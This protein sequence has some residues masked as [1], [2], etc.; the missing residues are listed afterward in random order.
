AA[1]YIPKNEINERITGV[2]ISYKLLELAN[3]YNKSIYL[4]GASKDVIE[5]TVK[6]INKEYPKVNILGYSNGYVDDKDDV[7]KRIK[8]ISPDI[9]LVAL[10][11]PKQELLIAKHYDSFSKG[12]FVGVGGTFDVISGTKKRAPQIIQR[13]NIEWL[14]R[15][16]GNKERI[17]R[18]YDSNVKFIFKL[19]KLAKEEK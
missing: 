5:L 10:G 11:V 12:I 9:I 1:N 14:Y 3:K 16:V 4:L 7:F 2:D 8:N 15:I 17:K 6:N 18:F 19:R 13:L